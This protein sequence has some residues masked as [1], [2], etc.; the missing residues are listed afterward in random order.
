MCMR[1]SKKRLAIIF[2]LYS[3]RTGRHYPERLRKEVFTDTVLQ[4]IGLTVEDYRR[5]RVF[6]AVTTMKIISY[7]SIPKDAL[8]KSV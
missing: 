5:T 2:E 7:F 3:R 8:D 4:E 6:D 1:I